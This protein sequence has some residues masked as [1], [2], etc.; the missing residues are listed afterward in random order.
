[1]SEGW[2]DEVRNGQARGGQARLAGREGRRLDCR[3]D[4][5]QQCKE[6]Q[7]R[8]EARSRSKLERGRM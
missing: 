6:K 8:D 4:D 7:Q 5:V 1:V 3:W 2:C